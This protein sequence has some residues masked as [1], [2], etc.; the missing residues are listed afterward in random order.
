L[1]KGVTVTGNLRENGR[2]SRVKLKILIFE[3]ETSHSTEIQGWEK[4]F[5]I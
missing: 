2:G 5:E 1:W 3:K 4:V